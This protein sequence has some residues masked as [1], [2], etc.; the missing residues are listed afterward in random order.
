MSIDQDLDNWLE[1]KLAQHTFKPEDPEIASLIALKLEVEGALIRAFQTTTPF[2]AVA[3]SFAKGTM[4]KD[5]YDLDLVCYFDS[6]DDTAGTS[7]DTIFASVQAALETHYRVKPNRSSMRLMGPKNGPPH[8]VHLDVVPGRF[9]GPEQ[10][11]V[12]LHQAEGEK[13]RLKTNLKRH[14]EYIRQSNRQRLIQLIK[15]WKCRAQLDI[16][17]FVLELAVIT[18][19]RGKTSN[20]L[21]ADFRYVLEQ[22][23]DNIEALRITDPANPGGNDLTTLFGDTERVMLSTSASLALDLAEHDG[24]SQVLGPLDPAVVGECEPGNTPE[25]LPLEAAMHLEAVPWP[26][27]IR[28]NVKLKCTGHW[29]ELKKT[30]EVISGRG[31]IRSNTELRFSAI[32]DIGGD[33]EVYW[34]V[35]N[36]GEHA[37]EEQC[38]RGEISKSSDPLRPLE[39]T[40]TTRYTGSHWV[41]CFIVQGGFLVARSGPFYVPIYNRKR[42]PRPSFLRKRR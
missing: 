38:L 9:V 10:R 3:G 42:R 22:F 32:T 18:A 5:S 12:Y 8:D 17:T 41:E 29:K 35:V 39:R 37:R 14:L 7:L 24:W 27:A 6:G 25:L 19:M 4:V 28:G 23:R 16:K 36:T 34:Q 11:D 13:K 40:E 2:I 15:I 21:D 31:A 1:A 33:Y 26:E 20:G 30:F